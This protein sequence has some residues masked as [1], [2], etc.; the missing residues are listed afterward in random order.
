MATTLLEDAREAAERLAKYSTRLREL[1]ARR[2]AL[3]AAV[4]AADDGDGGGVGGVADGDDACSADVSMLSC[5]SMYT[6]RT[7]AGIS[8][9]A[10]SSSGVGTSA[11][12]PSTL[13]GRRPQRKKQGRRGARPGRIRA[14]APG[15]AADLAKLLL[16]LGPRRHELEQAGALAELLVLLGH[17]EDA[18]A[19]QRTVG[20]WATAGADA[21]TLVAAGSE[22]VA[23]TVAPVNAGPGDTE[24][25]WKWD[26]LRDAK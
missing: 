26:A 5:L 12:P 10:P 21:A 3:D 17:A 6:D 22:V 23:A 2:A 14:G 1:R 13:G 11:A 8:V 18:A 4:A 16:T 19:L 20:V 7:D 25:V 24:V 9:L 15:E